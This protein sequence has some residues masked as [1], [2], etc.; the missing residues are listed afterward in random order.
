MISL[1]VALFGTSYNTWRNQTTEFHR[2]VRSAGFMM[3][4]ELG[5]L[6]EIT[7]R[8]FYGGDHSDANRIGG[9]GKATAVRDMSSLISEP[10]RAQARGLFE[11]WAANVDKLDSGDE[12]AEQAITK[13]ISDLRAQVL[14]E[15]Q[16]LN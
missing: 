8:R 15:M 9:W 2:N 13:T 6:Q 4:D 11:T 5:Q 10:T 16:S 14:Q 1:A 7:D 12:Q 3:L